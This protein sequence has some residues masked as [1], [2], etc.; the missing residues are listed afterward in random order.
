MSSIFKELIIQLQAPWDKGTQSKQIVFQRKFQKIVRYSQPDGK[1]SSIP[2]SYSLSWTKY[3]GQVHLLFVSFFLKDI[4]G[5]SQNPLSTNGS[6]WIRLKWCRCIY[7]GKAR[8][9]YRAM[10]C[11]IILLDPLC[12]II[13]LNLG[14]PSQLHKNIDIQRKLCVWV[15]LSDLEILHC[16]NIQ[17]CPELTL[18]WIYYWSKLELGK[19][20]GLS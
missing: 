7:W 12:N 15:D 1:K 10:Y 13:C 16:I 8:Q 14:P 2:F 17:L 4:Y 6:F 19:T 11:G 5:S 18:I 20:S 9:V 3:L